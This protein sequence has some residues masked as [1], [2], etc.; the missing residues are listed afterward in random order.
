M[1][2][3]PIIMTGESVRAILDGRKAQTRRVIKPQP[4][5]AFDGQWEFKDKYGKWIG[6]YN[7]RSGE[8][9]VKSPYQVGDR[10][11]VKETWA[12]GKGY[13]SLKP[14]DIQRNYIT[15]GYPISYSR[16]YPRKWYKAD[17]SL[18]EKHGIGKWHSPLFMPKAFAR[19]WLEVT[20]VKAE[21]LQDISEEDA[22][23]EGVPEW[24][25]KDDIANGYLL[26]RPLDDYWCPTC[27]GHGLHP[28]LGANYG[29]IE[30]EC[31]DCD[32]SIK[33]FRNRWDALNAKRGYP[34]ENNDWVWAYTFKRIEPPTEKK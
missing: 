9:N 5:E 30:V 8:R 21:R 26:D 6:A 12:V 15:A 23:A 31:R 7:P 14:L 34:W 10:L 27:Q 28:A 13:D 2:D 4:I 3:K 11:W 17:T 1:S 32:T 25:N 18:V 22:I 16:R 33:L 20:A 19:L 29:V 24:A